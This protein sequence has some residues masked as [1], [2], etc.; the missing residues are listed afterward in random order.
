MLQELCGKSAIILKLSLHSRFEGNV[1]AL[2]PR[3][4]N[5]NET[6]A[7][8]WLECNG[9][10]Q[11]VRREPGRVH[12]FPRFSTSALSQPEIMTFLL[13][14]FS[15]YT[16]SP[17]LHDRVQPAVAPRWMTLATTRPTRPLRNFGSI[18]R[19]QMSHV[20]SIDHYFYSQ[21]LNNLILI[22]LENQ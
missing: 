22:K 5:P 4:H 19:I 11:L 9:V 1:R 15:H 6:L 16:L 13:H 2:L 18:T 8:E 21:L 7:R 3:S 20:H 14:Y 12:S 17:F 10:A